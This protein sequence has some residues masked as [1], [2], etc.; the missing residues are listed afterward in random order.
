MTLNLRYSERDKRGAKPPQI[1]PA[2]RLS[3]PNLQ[4]LT[5]F[6]LL[7]FSFFLHFNPSINH[8]HEPHTRL[9]T[10][11]NF[12]LP[13]TN[14]SANIHQTSRFSFILIHLS[15]SKAASLTDNSCPPFLHNLQPLGIVNFAACTSQTFLTFT[16]ISKTAAYF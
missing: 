13:Y 3:V 1:K 7:P 4:Y 15:L 6:F 14:T 12:P 10:L 2:S 11:F 16:T 5:S 8:H 9:R